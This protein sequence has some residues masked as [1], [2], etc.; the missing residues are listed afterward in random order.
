MA[1]HD[2]QIRA[3]GEF[4]PTAELISAVGDRLDATPG[5]IDPIL[6]ADARARVIELSVEVEAADAGDAHRRA[7]DALGAALVGAGVTVGWTVADR[8]RALIG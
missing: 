3:L 2:V 6:S 7:A 1:S 8:G 4:A 5:L